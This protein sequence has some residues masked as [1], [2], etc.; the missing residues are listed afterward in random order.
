[1]G[2]TLVFH[3]RLHPPACCACTAEEPEAST[4]LA[5]AASCFATRH[6]VFVK[7]SVQRAALLTQQSII[8]TSDCCILSA[9]HIVCP[10]SRW[11][12]LQH[13]RRQGARIGCSAEFHRGWLPALAQSSRSGLPSAQLTRK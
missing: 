13:A 2:G 1:M 11:G 12:A 7:N 3:G 4:A 5:E 6:V 9:T 10:A 8:H